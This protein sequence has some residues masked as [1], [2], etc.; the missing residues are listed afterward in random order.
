M[1]F[2]FVLI[3]GIVNGSRQIGRSVLYILNPAVIMQL[4]VKT[5]LNLKENHP[6]FVYSD[7][8]LTGTERQRIEVKVESRLGSKGICSGCGKKCAGYD[9]LPQREFIHVPLWGIAVIFLYSMRRLSCPTCGVTVEAVP[10]SAGKSPLTISYA[11]FLSEWAKL[12]SM[13]EVASQFRASWHHV[14]SAVAMAVAWGRE[15]MDLSGITAIGVDEI[16]WSKKQGF[17][18]LV[19]QID[20][21]CKRLLWCGENRTEKTIATFFDWFGELRSAKLKFVCSDMW[22]PYLKLIAL[23]AQ[24]ALNILD[25]FH[26]AQKLT[27]AID[28]V[29]T[30]ETKELMRKGKPVILKH[31]RWCF[32]K[33]PKNLTDNQKV[34]LKDLLKCNLKTIRAYL[35]KEDFQDFWTYTSPAWAGKFLD[36]WCTQVMRSKLEPMKKVAKTIRAHR[37]LILNWFEAKNVISLGAVEGQN[38]KAKV[39]IR[40]SYGFKTSDMLK[41]A[42]YH[43]LGKLPVPE[44]AHEYF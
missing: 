13:Q 11:W 7:V 29:R 37:Q 38:N 24:N 26:I 33:N 40:K 43:K 36:Q 10:W 30:A 35:L 1:H 27:D 20:N 3:L 32:L 25:R 5:I 19:Y 9:R 15:R 4:S 42:L 6:H 12:L 22:K 39:V 28:E 44:L 14:F 8:R 17:M 34:K 21:H 41:I 31:S 23:R 18:T 16:H 2:V